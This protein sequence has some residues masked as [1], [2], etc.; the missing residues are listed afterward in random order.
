[1]PNLAEP[2][3]LILFHD[4]A[5]RIPVLG[6]QQMKRKSITGKNKKEEKDLFIHQLERELAQSR[7]DMRSITEEQEATN[8]ELQSAN[9]ELQSGSEECKTLNEELETSKE[10]LQSTNEELTSLNQELLSMNR[11]LTTA[12]N[13]AVDILETV[14]EPWIVLDS[15]LRIKSANQVFYKTLEPLKPQ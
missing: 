15:N 12:R 9:E 11:N 7:E 14:R 6:Y 4:P 1:M 2:Y 10:E 5:G 3:Y 13:F 8:E